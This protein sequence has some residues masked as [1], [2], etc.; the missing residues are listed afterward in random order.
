MF[1]LRGPEAAAIASGF[2]RCLLPPAAGR[3][4]REPASHTGAP[5]ERCG[6]AHQWSALRYRALGHVLAPA[7]LRP[8]PLE[9]AAS[10]VPEALFPG[11]L[12]P[13]GEGGR[14]RPLRDVTSGSDSQFLTRSLHGARSLLFSSGPQDKTFCAISGT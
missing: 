2:P 12:R 3:A 7:L 4:H 14:T 6:P 10:A 13:P 11:V 1:Q 9:A 5:G 8:R